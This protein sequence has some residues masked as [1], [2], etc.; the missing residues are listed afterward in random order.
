M[1][2]TRLT[3]SMA[4][5]AGQTQGNIQMRKNGRTVWNEEDFDA[6]AKVANPLLRIIYKRD[7]GIDIPE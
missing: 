3:Q 5:A 7:H 1:N 6:A 4:Y 2:K